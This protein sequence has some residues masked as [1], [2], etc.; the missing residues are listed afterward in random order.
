MLGAIIGDIIGSCYEHNNVKTKDFVLFPG[1][2][3]FT[4]DTVMTLA[5]AKWLMEDSGHSKKGLVR[6]MQ[7]LGCRYLNAGYGGQ[8]YQWIISDRPAPYNSWG[9]GSAMRVSPVGLYASSMDEVL[10]LAEMSSVVTHNHPEGI[11]GAQAIAAAVFL[12]RTQKGEL[13]ERKRVIKNYIQQTF[14]YNLER[15]L[16]EIRPL[17]K[18]DVSCQGSVPESIIAFLESESLEDCVRNAISIGG[19]SDTVAAM[20]CSIFMAGR[21]CLKAEDTNQ[22]IIIEQCRALLDE[23]L[24]GIADQFESFLDSRRPVELPHG[25]SACSDDFCGDEW[26]QGCLPKGTVIYSDEKHTK[27]AFVIDDVVE[28]KPSYIVYKGRE[29]VD[30]GDFPPHFIPIEIAELFLSSETRREDG[31][32]LVT[33]TCIASLSEMPF[34]QYIAEHSSLSLKRIMELYREDYGA[35]KDFIKANNTLYYI[36]RNIERSSVCHSKASSKINTNVGQMKHG[37]EY[38]SNMFLCKECGFLCSSAFIYCPKC[39]RKLR[40]ASNGQSKWSKWIGRFI[41]LL[42]TWLLCAM[43]KGLINHE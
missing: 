16:D 9:N 37:E 11:K 32:R 13:Q 6:T 5:V 20:A 17:Y 26:K 38:T 22:R 42:I 18:F 33:R 2:S 39:G 10:S 3:S 24:L 27:P 8:F 19:D 29:I 31:M 36:N 30:Y 4:D 28:K 35:S 25:Q 23:Y 34:Y 41:V 15:T 7:Q 40:D 12:N 1:G 21:D 43:I 14:G